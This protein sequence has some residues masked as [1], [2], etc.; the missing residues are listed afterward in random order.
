MMRRIAVLAL[1][2][3][4]VLPVSA[5]RA[6]E[7]VVAGLSQNSIGITA[8]FDGSQILIYGAVK[9]ETPMPLDSSLQVIVTVEGPPGALTI[10]KKERRAGIWVNTEAVGVAGTPSFYAIASTAP[11]SEI[12]NPDEDVR[13]RISIPLALRSFDGPLEVSDAT[14]FTEALLR[15]REDEGL[16]NLNETGVALEEETLFRADFTLPASL[17]EGDYKTRMFLLRDGKVIDQH[18]AAI[19]VRRVGLE[20]FV[21][22]LSQENPMAY[23]A[24]SLVLAVVAGW[25]ASAVFRMFNK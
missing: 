7:T 12:L 6:E 22:A 1:A 25:T 5:P 11:L 10:R 3:A 9:R 2:A 21:Y 17:T 13:Q 15:I 20:R 18:R 14:P 19:H 24:I 8:S 23:G 4:L 16:Y